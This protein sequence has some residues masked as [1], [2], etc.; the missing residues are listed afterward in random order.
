M[1]TINRNNVHLDAMLNDILNKMLFDTN[2]L[3]FI[4]IKFIIAY[5]FM[6]YDTQM[7]E[8]VLPKSRSLVI[9]LEY[10]LELNFDTCM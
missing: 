6:V 9:P 4:D 2:E 10:I 3:K 5:Y 7:Q 8:C 1:F